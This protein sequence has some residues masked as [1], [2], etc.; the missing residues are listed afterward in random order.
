MEAEEEEVVAVV[1]VVVVVQRP[2]GATHHVTG[3]AV[4]AR[5]PSSRAVFFAA[6]SFF[7]LV[8]CRRSCVASSL[9]TVASDSP[10]I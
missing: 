1:A 10:L 2:S 6:F 7:D 3:L 8:S 5:S 4:S 9:P